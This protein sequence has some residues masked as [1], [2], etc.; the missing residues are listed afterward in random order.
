[1]CKTMLAALKNKIYEDDV[2]VKTLLISKQINSKIP[3][4]FVYIGIKLSD[5]KDNTGMVKVN[6]NNAISLFQGSVKQAVEK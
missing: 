4:N 2:Q 5:Y 6:I 3:V 1:M